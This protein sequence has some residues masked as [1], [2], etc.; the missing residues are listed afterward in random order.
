MY[1]KAADDAHVNRLTQHHHTAGREVC[2]VL[3]A[4]AEHAWHKPVQR[5]IAMWRQLQHE[6]HFQKT[7]ARLKARR[8]AEKPPAPLPRITTADPPFSG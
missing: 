2:H 6:R 8:A 3:V 4:P 7:H 1:H 5:V